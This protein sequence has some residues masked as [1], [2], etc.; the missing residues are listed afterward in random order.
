M[1]IDS[2][3][4]FLVDDKFE[5]SVE[6]VSDLCSALMDAAIQSSMGGIGG[7]K[8]FDLSDF[9]EWQHKYILGYLE[10]ECRDSMRIMLEAYEEKTWQ[11]L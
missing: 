5:E 3:M 7:C 11:K 6:K 1:R 10:Y 4:G 2:V 8:Q 9:P